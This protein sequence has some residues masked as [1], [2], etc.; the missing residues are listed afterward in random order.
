MLHC[1]N[2]SPRDAR[3][4]GADELTTRYREL[5][6]EL[7]RAYREPE[8]DAARIDAIADALSPIER[9]LAAIRAAAAPEAD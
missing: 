3:P 6:E 7:D 2:R 1:S 8:W 5:R 9:R 4:M